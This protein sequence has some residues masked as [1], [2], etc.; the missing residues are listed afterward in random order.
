VRDEYAIKAQREGYRARS[1]YKFM[2]I[3]ERFDI[4]KSNSKVIDI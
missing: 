3:Q 4:I 2:E 1:V